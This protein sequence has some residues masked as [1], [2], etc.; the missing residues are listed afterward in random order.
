[1][2][3]TF[4]VNLI[5]HFQENNQVL[6]QSLNKNIFDQEIEKELVQEIKFVLFQMLKLIPEYNYENYGKSEE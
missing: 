5:K 3:S 6:Y 4:K 2:L 1:M